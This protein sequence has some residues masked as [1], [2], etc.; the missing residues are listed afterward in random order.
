MRS[1]ALPATP[2]H[3]RRRRPLR[4]T[5]FHASPPAALPA[6]AWDPA[7]LLAEGRTIDLDPAT[8]DDADALALFSALVGATQRLLHTAGAP[9]PHIAVAFSGGVDSS[10]AAALCVRALVENS[11]NRS[12]PPTTPPSLSLYLGV[13]PALSPSQ[14]DRARAVASS[15]SVPLVEVPTPEGSNSDYI[16][17]EGLACR[18]C[19]DA[20]YSTLDWVGRAAL[21]E[22][23][24][25][26][27]PA[28]PGPL[29]MVNGT[30]ADD[31]A[32]PSRLGLM[33]ATDWKVVSPLCQVTKRA[34]R[35]VARAAGLPNW[36]DA[37]SPCL[38]SRLALG[39]RAEPEM[40]GR[41]AMAEAATA[42]ELELDRTR[43][44]RASRQG[45]GAGV[46]VCSA[47]QGRHVSPP[48]P[49]PHS[50]RPTTRAAGACRHRCR[51][52]GRA[53]SRRSRVR[54]WARRRRRRARRC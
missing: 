12:T 53:R 2:A 16:D 6:S 31:L 43:A 5:P 38:R 1:S 19:K 49:P 22:P 15:L 3:R 45:G 11:R 20:L 42:E 46:L 29:L 27:P 14:H 8:A 30:N 17:N 34:V 32:D 10:L 28:T 4:D 18:A 21:T 23:L 37:A 39:V 33:S 44:F 9:P 48:P 47:V 25:S 13:S 51:R 7:A 41:V 52:H 36:N 24:S 26:S 50:R 54:R 40:L 35:T